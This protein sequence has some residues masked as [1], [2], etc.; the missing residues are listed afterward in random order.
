MTFPVA[1]PI[2]QGFGRPALSAEPTMW[3]A[4]DE[5]RCRP[6][7]FTGAVLYADVHP[8]VDVMCPVGTAIK[9]PDDGVLV[10]RETYRIFNPFTGSYVWG[11]SIYFRFYKAGQTHILYVDH[12][13]KYVAAEGARVKEGG[14]L[15]RTGDSGIVTGPHAHIE[16]RIA[17]DPHESWAAFRVNPVKSLA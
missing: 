8:G 10:R 5:S 7:K 4:K 11:L 14:L 13:S 9:A 12:L 2:S 6:T 17:A 15:G 1:G 16:D 3:L